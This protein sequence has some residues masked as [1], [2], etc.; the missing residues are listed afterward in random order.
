MGWST[1]NLQRVIDLLAIRQVLFQ[2]PFRICDRRDFA[3]TSISRDNASAGCFEGTSAIS[4]RRN[5]GGD[6]V[7]YCTPPDVVEP[8]RRRVVIQPAGPAPIA[9]NNN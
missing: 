6:H 4:T 9:F 5:S 7:P 3:R 8:A 2:S 1:M